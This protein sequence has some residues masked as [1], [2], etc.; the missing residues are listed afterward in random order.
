M[1]KIEEAARE[2]VLQYVSED[3]AY[4]NPLCLAFRG[5][6]RHVLDAL[7]SNEISEF[8]ARYILAYIAKHAQQPISSEVLAAIHKEIESE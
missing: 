3:S 2:F 6:A 4:F 5:G 1:T 8:H 7:M